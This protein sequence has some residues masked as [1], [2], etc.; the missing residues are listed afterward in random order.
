V[1][2]VEVIGLTKQFVRRQG[3]RRVRVTALDGVSFTIARGE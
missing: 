1:P 2:A 3:R